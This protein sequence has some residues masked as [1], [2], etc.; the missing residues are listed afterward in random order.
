MRIVVTQAHVDP[1]SPKLTLDRSC[2]TLRPLP[3]AWRDGR[4]TVGHLEVNLKCLLAVFVSVMGVIGAFPARPAIAASPE[5]EAAA[6]TISQI[7]DDPTKF[8]AYCQIAK[9]I[10]AA[11]SEPA[12][13]AI[14]EQEIEDLVRSFGPAYERA[15]ELV[16]SGALEPDDEQALED[17]FADLEER[18]SN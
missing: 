3:H 5:V 10:D 18:C 9:A 14:L 13:Y 2:V 12:K 11:E 6:Q 16:K 1:A 17:A 15:M 8:G 4:A 7:A